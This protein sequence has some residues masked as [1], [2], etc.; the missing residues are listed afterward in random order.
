MRPSP[1]VRGTGEVVAVVVVVV[2]HVDAGRR[3]ACEVSS[4]GWSS[5]S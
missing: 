5:S 3:R 4:S 1:A 2:V